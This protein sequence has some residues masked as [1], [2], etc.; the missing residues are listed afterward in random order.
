MKRKFKV[1]LLEQ[2]AVAILGKSSDI[3]SRG[4]TTKKV[5]CYTWG[6]DGLAKT[7]P[8]RRSGLTFFGSF[9]RLQRSPWDKAKKNL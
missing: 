6:G 8:N 1:I 5:R 2:V 7:R 9:L 3:V 4:K